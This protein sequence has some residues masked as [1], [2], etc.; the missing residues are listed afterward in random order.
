MQDRTFRTY[1]GQVNHFYLEDSW[2]V[3]RIISEFVE[4]FEELSEVGPAVTV[5]GSARA[6]RESKDY[7]SARR[8]GRLFAEAG[9][10]IITGGGPGIMEAANRGAQEAGGLS[11]GLNIEIPLEQQPNRYVGKLITFRYFFVR[12]VML[13]KYAKAFIVYPGGY[14]TLDEL[15]E[16]LTL[17]QTHRI[18]RFPI[19]L[20]RRRYWQGLLGWLANP[21]AKMRKISP[22]DLELYDVAEEPEE[23]L[24]IVQR[25]YEDQVPDTT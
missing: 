2:R 19:V 6:G 21:V 9:Y 8:L 14:G 25:F 17:I 24:S 15:F 11:V 10:T 7:E 20:M 16:A 1:N 3:F 13:V 12:K 5:F 18:R 22:E 23:A 4:G